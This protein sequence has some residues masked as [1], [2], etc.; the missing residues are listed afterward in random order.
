MMD[1][2]TEAVPKRALTLDLRCCLAPRQ[3]RQPPCESALGARVQSL[4]FF[5][6]VVDRHFAV[7]ATHVYNKRRLP[8][9]QIT[10]SGAR[11]FD[12]TACGSP[13]FVPG[14]RDKVFTP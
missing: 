14:P 13:A 6:V 4:L 12:G 8:V 9:C 1:G 10:L 3:L 11:N 2:M 5:C 7:A